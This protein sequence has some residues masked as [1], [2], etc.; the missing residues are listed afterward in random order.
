MALVNHD[1][2]RGDVDVQYNVPNS[3]CDEA[4]FTS[5]YED[6]DPSTFDPPNATDAQWGAVHAW[7]AG[8]D[9]VVR[10]AKR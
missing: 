3:D 10:R 8:M 4:K 5:L 9:D 2:W 6:F 1:V 7:R